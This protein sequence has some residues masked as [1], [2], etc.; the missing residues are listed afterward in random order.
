VYIYY[1]THHY[2]Y[3]I[4]RHSIIIAVF[5]QLSACARAVVHAKAITALGVAEK[6]TGRAARLI[7][8]AGRMAVQ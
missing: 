4:R 7:L 5:S 6:A 8:C 1:D 3:N 2:K